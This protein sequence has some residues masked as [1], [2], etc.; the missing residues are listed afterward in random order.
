M[1]SPI[2]SSST[3]SA[4]G[5][6]EPPDSEPPEEEEEPAPQVG[7]A[8]SLTW[9]RTKIASEVACLFPCEDAFGLAKLKMP[10]GGLG[11]KMVEHFRSGDASPVRVD[12]DRELSRNPQLKQ[13]VTSQIEFDLALRAGS[14]ERVED[15]SGAVWVSQAE[16]GTS[17]AGE[18]QRLALGGTFFE[19]QVVGT[20]ADGGLMTRVNVSDHYFWSPKEERPTQCF[21]VCGAKMVAEG[22]ATEFHQLG[23]GLLTVTDPGVGSPMAPP[24]LESKGQ[25]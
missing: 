20:A 11:E 25:L 7:L 16:Y 3:P 1:P 2:S 22:K 21:H 4:A 9:Y 10:D 13:F 12:L 19:Y 18:D 5:A 8:H 15:M 14:G 17:E 23:E 24:A 6:P